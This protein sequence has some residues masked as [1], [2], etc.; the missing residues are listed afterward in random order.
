MK[1]METPNA[2]AM[3]D[4]PS[5]HPKSEHLRPRHDSMLPTRQTSEQSVG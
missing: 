2:E 4:R 3:L 5:A 1:E